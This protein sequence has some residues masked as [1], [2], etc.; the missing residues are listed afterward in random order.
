MAWPKLTMAHDYGDDPKQVIHPYEPEPR[1]EPRPAVVF[2]H[3]GGLIMG[4]PMWESPFAK[5]LA[6]QGFVAF[7]AGYRLYDPA[8][9]SNLW[10]TQLDDAQRAI[11]WVR[12]HADE[13]NVDPER[14]C[15]FGYSAGGYLVGLLGTHD[16]RDDSDP[17]LAG[18]SSRPDC[19]FMGAGDG[20]LR[21]RIPS[22]P[23]TVS[24]SAISWPA[25]SVAPSTRCRRSGRRPRRLT[26]SMRTPRPSW[27]STAATTSTP[28]RDVPQLRG[29]MHEAGPGRGVLELPGGHM[30]VP[31]DPQFGTAIERFLVDRMHPEQ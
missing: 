3:G 25:G 29:A 16:T 24:W 23:W 30:E 31:Y 7:M 10:P 5:W 14:V 17:D 6:E 4:E 26:T 22:G 15:A 12:A 13:F 18:I 19:V 11:R 8:N 27:S 9:D 1:A 2:L 21:S 20:D 28:R